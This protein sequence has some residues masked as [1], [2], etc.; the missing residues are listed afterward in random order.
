MYKAKFGGSARDKK[1]VRYSW[2]AGDEIEASEGTLDH[3]DGLEW[4]G[5]K[6]PKKKELEFKNLPNEEALAEAG[7]DTL[8]K[9]K[10]ATDEE[11][12]EVNG[13]GNSSLKK[14]RELV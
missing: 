4:A 1:G 11:L 3:V 10:S 2:N 7:F 14:I 9:V 12:L 6:K 13:I 8:E 5:K